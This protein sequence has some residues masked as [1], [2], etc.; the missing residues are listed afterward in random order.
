MENDIILKINVRKIVLWLVR[1]FKENEKKV[2][3]VI[4][5]V[6]IKKG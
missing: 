4:F 3:K 1:N 6:R 5:G 2:F